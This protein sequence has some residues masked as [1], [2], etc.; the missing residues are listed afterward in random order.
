MKI[1][2]V[3]KRSGV[4]IETIRFYEREGLLRPAER[5]PSGYRQYDESAL[6]RLGY[7][8]RAKELGFTLAEIRELLE[9]SFTAHAGCDHIRKRA[10]AKITDIEN[11]IRNLQQM[12]RSLRTI[13]AQCKEKDSPHDC[14]L[15]HGGHDAVESPG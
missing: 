12:R 15:V 3:A 14:P 8:C 6:K 10:E 2:E 9:L 11:R 7:V 5:R 13:V 1:G 4:S